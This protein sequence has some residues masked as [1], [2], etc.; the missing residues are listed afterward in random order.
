MAIFEDATNSKPVVFSVIEG[1][2]DGKIF[3]DNDK[4]PKTALIQLYDMFFL[5][6]ETNRDFCENIFNLLV[7]EVFPI[8]DEEYFDFYCLS[9]NLRDDVEE[10]FAS[11]IHSK[12]VRKTFTFDRDKFERHRGWRERLPE[13]YTMDMFKGPLSVKLKLD[14]EVVSECS[15][16]FAGAGQAEISVRTNEKYRK[17]GFAALACAA[18]IEECLSEGY[19]P[20][21]TCWDF[22]EGSA[23]LARKMGFVELKD[24][25]VYGIKK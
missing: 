24:D 13:R 1:N 2:T 3:V 22:R 25:I 16:V 4:N 8:M 15:A 12:L 7:N 11:L 6:G 19:I 10:I 23:E 5:K 21:W 17:Q 18:F 9:D 14:N 20:N